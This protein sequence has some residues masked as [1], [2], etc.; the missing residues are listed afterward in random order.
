MA[1]AE[2]TVVMITGGAQGIGEGIARR[3]AS[4][5][6]AIAIA[7]LNGEKA[8]AV[9]E[10]LKG[11]GAVGA[12]SVQ[13]DVAD[14][15]SLGRPDCHRN[16][17]SLSSAKRVLQHNFARTG[18]SFG[19]KS[20]DHWARPAVFERCKGIPGAVKLLVS[21]GF[22]AEQSNAKSSHLYLPRRARRD[23][24]GHPYVIVFAI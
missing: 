2:N 11:E 17:Y 22:A 19:L 23:E 21:T 18:R 3:L 1:R 12:I 10:T 6:A 4:E 20:P 8:K 16:R 7:D 5:G 9:A 15:G 24:T 13:V 14:R